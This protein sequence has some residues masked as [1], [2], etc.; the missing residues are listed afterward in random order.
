MGL[1]HRSGASPPADR[2]SR[3]RA[4]S[5][6]SSDER[7]WTTTPRSLRAPRGTV[8]SAAVLLRQKRGRLAGRWG[9]GSFTDVSEDGAM[10]ITEDGIGWGHNNQTLCRNLWKEDLKSTVKDSMAGLGN[11]QDSE[12][13]RDGSLV[14]FFRRTATATAL[15]GNV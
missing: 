4:R 13:A 15:S 8:G 5:S 1:T 14:K 3:R 9:T 11:F 6:R 2:Q 7:R 12:D 10:P